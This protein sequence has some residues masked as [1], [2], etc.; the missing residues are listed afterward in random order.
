MDNYE[1]FQELVKDSQ[2]SEGYL[3]H[4]AEIY[5]ESWEG[6]SNRARAA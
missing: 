1:R 6:A 5:A 4:Q 2:D 3:Q